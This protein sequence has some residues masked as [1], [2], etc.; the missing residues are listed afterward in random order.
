MKPA[1]KK[2]D[3]KVWAL[4]K[5]GVAPKD[6]VGSLEITI[7]QVYHALKRERK[8]RLPKRAKTRQARSLRRGVNWSR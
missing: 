2:M 1:T 7:D 3:A 4:W 6:I 8:R 5:D